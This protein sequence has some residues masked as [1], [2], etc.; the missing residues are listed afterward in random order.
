MNS[1]KTFYSRSFK[2]YVT[3]KEELDYILA[4]D[5]EFTDS[6]ERVHEI[7]EAI[8]NKDSVELETYIDM[9]TRGLSKGVAKAINTMVK[10]KEYMLNAVKYEYSNG[11][12]EGFNNKIKLLK[13]EFLMDTL[14]LVISNYSF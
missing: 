1:T 14:A 4:I 12:L 11:P 10:H 2:R 13:L 6:Y 3:R 7:R 5:A 8:K 9:D